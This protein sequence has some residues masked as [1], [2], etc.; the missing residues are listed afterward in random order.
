MSRIQTILCDA[1]GGEI[2]LNVGLF[3]SVRS[4]NTDRC[5]DF[6]ICPA[7]APMFEDALAIGL[8]RVTD[9]NGRKLIVT[10]EES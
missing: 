1:C 8:R 7:C 5:S 10:T 4:R 6:D 3:V 9:G 2:K